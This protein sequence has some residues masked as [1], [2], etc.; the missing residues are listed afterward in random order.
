MRA[1]LDAS[2]LLVKETLLKFQRSSD[3]CKNV[4]KQVIGIYLEC[5]RL[6]R[7]INDTQSESTVDQVRS[8]LNHW[9]NETMGKKFGVSKSSWS[10]RQWSV[11]QAEAEIKVTLRQ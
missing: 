4:I 5:I 7:V 1:T 9:V 2:L 8:C 10:S 3:D 6:N 11:A